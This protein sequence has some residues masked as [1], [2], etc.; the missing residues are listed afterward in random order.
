YVFGLN[1]P[2]DTLGSNGEGLFYVQ[3]KYPS[4]SSNMT[5]A[6]Y[7]EAQLVVAEADIFGGNYGLG[8][9]IMDTLRAGFTPA[10]GPVS[11]MT[12]ASRK[13]QILQVLSERAYWMY[14]TGHRLGDWRRM[15]RAPYNA[16]P[17]SFVTG[18]V[19]PVGAG[20]QNTLEFPTPTN[21]NPNP[22]YQA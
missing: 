13:N 11:D 18:D 19:Y 7:T 14:V 20:I 6:D 16:A 9:A 3:Q 12:A 8:R 15:L 1:D 4:S 17:F 21:T 10:M 5:L 2:G 22:N